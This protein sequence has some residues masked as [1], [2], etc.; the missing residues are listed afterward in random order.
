MDEWIQFCFEGLPGDAA[1][2][3]LAARGSLFLLVATRFAGFFAIGP[4]LG[5]ATVSWPVRIGLVVMLTLIVAPGLVF[6]AQETDIELVAHQPASTL[7]TAPSNLWLAVLCEAAI[8]GSL[9]LAVAIFLSGLKLAGEWLD[10]HSAQGIGGILNPEF[11]GTGSAPADIAAMLCLTTILIMQPINGHLLLVRL[12][13]DSFHS[14]PVGIIHFPGTALDL[15][16][17]ILQQAMLLGLRVAMPFVVAMSL[18]DMT[19]AW[20]RRSSRWD[21]AAS[22]SPFRAI[23]SILIL[24]ATFPGISEAVST[25]VMDTLNIA[26]N[27]LSAP[28]VSNEVQ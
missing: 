2:Q 18:F 23:A 10:R 15:I 17:S 11:T 4:L 19:L 7:P 16:R 25:T 6:P 3:L 22:T 1:L 9:G 27:S 28:H 26:D 12:L 5:R 24:T 8:G 14:L 20:V 21:L 13:L